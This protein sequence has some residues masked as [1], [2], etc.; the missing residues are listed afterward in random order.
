MPS[1][2]SC[3]SVE[4]L[5]RTKP[6][7]FHHQRTLYIHITTIITVLSQRPWTEIGLF[8]SKIGCKYLNVNK[9]VRSGLI[10][11]RLGKARLMGSALFPGLQCAFQEWIPGRACSP[12]LETAVQEVWILCD[13]W[14]LWFYRAWQHFCV[15]IMTLR[16][17]ISSKAL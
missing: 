8:F 4:P 14:A 1:C 6:Q 17:C 13:W 7:H 2:S 16:P 3:F 5:W 12:S 10:L 11:T 15:T 9:Q